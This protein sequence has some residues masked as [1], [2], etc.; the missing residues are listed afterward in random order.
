MHIVLAV[1]AALGTAYF[2]VMR[3]RNAAD[4]TGELMDVAADVRNA[5]RRLG[6]RR[7]ANIHPAEAVEDPHM[8]IATIATAFVELDDLPTR[9]QRDALVRQMQS[10][11]SIPLE[12]AEELSVFGRWMVQ[13]CGG[14]EPAINRM[15]RKLYRMGGAEHFTA[16]LTVIQGALGA[17]QLNIRQ[18]EALDDVRRAFRIP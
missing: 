15:A 11:L 7:K 4:M 8:A 18:S 3:A 14:A 16:L 5:A 17:A 6:F 13:E 9:E 10:T 12:T 1:I 2:F